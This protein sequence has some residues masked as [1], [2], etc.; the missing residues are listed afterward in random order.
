M[1]QNRGNK[2]CSWDISIIFVS[3]NLLYIFFAC[4]D[5]FVLNELCFFNVMHSVTAPVLTLRPCISNKFMLS[6]CYL[7]LIFSLTLAAR[8]YIFSGAARWLL[9]L[10]NQTCH[11][12][13]H[14]YENHDQHNNLYKPIFPQQYYFKSSLH[15][16]TP[17]ILHKQSSVQIA[18]VSSWHTLRA[19]NGYYIH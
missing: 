10:I 6:S 7:V 14:I 8:V 2:N 3:Y 18:F 1:A 11:S 13:S 9:C 12:T 5:F 16:G 4:F 19:I 15:T 17:T